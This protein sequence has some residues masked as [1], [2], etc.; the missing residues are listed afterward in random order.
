MLA[1]QWCR[2]FQLAFDGIAASKHLGDVLVGD[3]ALELGIWHGL[4]SRQLVLDREHAK[5]EQVSSEPDRRRSPASSGFLR[6]SG[7]QPLRPPGSWRRLV[8]G[9]I[10]WHALV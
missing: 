8:G 1:R 4:R 7:G 9:R 6:A 2:L 3:L 5:E 10:G